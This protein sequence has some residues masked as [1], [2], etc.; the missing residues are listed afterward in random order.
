MLAVS[1]LLLRRGRHVPGIGVTTLRPTL[2]V[3]VGG[4]VVHVVIFGGVHVSNA[5]GPGAQAL[6]QPVAIRFAGCF[7][8]LTRRVSGGNAGISVKEMSRGG[9]CQHAS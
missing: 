7:L 6:P 1:V 3:G 8:N 5:I 9:S 4:A 2:C